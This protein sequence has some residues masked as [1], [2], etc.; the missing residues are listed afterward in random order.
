MTTGLMPQAGA[1]LLRS[2]DSEESGLPGTDGVHLSEKE[3]GIFSLKLA[4][5]VMETSN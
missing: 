1:W 3:G 2:Y 5:L 4:K